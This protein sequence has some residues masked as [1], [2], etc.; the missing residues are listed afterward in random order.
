MSLKVG[1]DFDGNNW[2][3]LFK[4]AGDA[5]NLFGALA[6][7]VDDL[8]HG[9][10]A[11][12]V[13]AVASKAGHAP[14][15]VPFYGAA[16]LALSSLGTNDAYAIGYN[17]GAAYDLTG[18]ASGTY[19]GSLWVKVSSVSSP[20]TLRL[21]MISA[22][23]GTLFG[24]TTHVVT[25][26]WTQL[27]ITGSLPY[28]N[29]SIYLRLSVTSGGTDTVYVSG[30]M[31]V[32]GST[33]PEYLNCG[34]DSQYE[35][36]SDHVQRARWRSGFVRP[37]QYIA[38]IGRATLTLTNAD[39][40]FSPEYS[41][42]V[43]WASPDART[44]N[45]RIQ[46]IA[47]ND[48]SVIS[49]T[50]VSVLFTG[51]VN[52]WKPQAGVNSARM[53]EVECLDAIDHLH[54][55]EI[56]P[57]LK[58]SNTPEQLITHLINRV[59]K[60]GKVV[61]TDEYSAGATPNHFDAIETETVP[62]YF[63]QSPNESER[64]GQQAIS[65]LEDILTG[66][67]AKLWV[68]R[69]GTVEYAGPSSTVGPIATFDNTAISL[70]YQW[71]QTIVNECT[72][73]AYPRRAGGSTTQRL[74]RLRESLTVEA[75]ETEIV[76]AYFT[77]E[78]TDIRCGSEPG[79][80][81]LS[82]LTYSGAG[83]AAS[84]TDVDAMSCEISVVNS[85]GVARDWTAGNVLGRELSI[86]DA[87]A[88]TRADSTS[89]TTN[90]RRAEEIDSRWVAKGKWAKRLAQF[91]VNRFKDPHGEVV[92][93]TGRYDIDSQFADCWI[94]NTINVVDDQLEHDGD[95]VIVGEDHRWELGNEH[96]VKL[97]LEPAITETVGTTSV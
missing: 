61:L 65:L 9:T 43:I 46:I 74:W 47:D 88:R 25:T 42:S 36:I 6:A 83:L 12:S 24:G 39:K 86:E 10:V 37:Y 17:G 97:F 96:W 82:G 62:Y 91:R 59:E 15:Q 58:T 30:P 89:I 53:C 18:Q 87:I 8:N 26:A 78:D 45:Q 75:G 7:N 64:R 1:V 33:A 13:T 21:D 85:T 4:A 14:T 55:V 2:V 49:P 63:D 73:K 3:E 28:S 22:G 70:D 60:D 93:L 56:F 95:Y 31:I 35:N 57:Q 50:S 27:T 92:S 51:F 54:D 29:Q 5:D 66:I 79:T 71:A 34:T 69:W 48:A 52:E 16:G 90:G 68:N 80:V 44:F 40:R 77:R 23:N 19:T 81:A 84:I 94:G 72:A 67:Q 38:G 76:R 32:A 11:G 41:S 20:P